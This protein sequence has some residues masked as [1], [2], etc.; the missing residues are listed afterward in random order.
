M[1]EKNNVHRPLKFTELEKKGFPYAFGQ[2]IIIWS[3]THLSIYLLLKFY[4]NN[5]ILEKDN[6]IFSASQ[7]KLVEV[8]C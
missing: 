3:L 5:M 8:K 4:Q 2:K 6:K 1:D 7:T